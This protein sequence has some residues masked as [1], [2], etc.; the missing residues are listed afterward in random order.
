MYIGTACLYLSGFCPRLS[1]IGQGNILLIDTVIFGI[2]C[3]RKLAPTEN[4]SHALSRSF[5][6][7]KADGSLILRFFYDRNI[8]EVDFD[9]NGGEG[10]EPDPQ[11]V[12]EL[13]RLCPHILTARSFLL[14]MLHAV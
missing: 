7:V 3:E 6:T 4:K 5:G 8:Y 9:L 12:R 14:V 1:F 13:F 11:S 10:E 2:C